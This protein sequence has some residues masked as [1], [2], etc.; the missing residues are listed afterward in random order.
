MIKM[1]LLLAIVDDPATKEILQDQISISGMRVLFA[2]PQVD[3][4]PSLLQN[5]FSLILID[6]SP[7]H[8]PKEVC[9][10][11]KQ[12]S[13]A[14]VLVTMA[15]GGEASIPGCLATCASDCIIKPFRVSELQ[16][17]IQALLARN[18]QQKSSEPILRCSKV[19]L[20]TARR[21]VFREGKEVKVTRTGYKLLVYFMQHQS[22][23]ISKEELLR[24]V[25]GYPGEHAGNN[26]VESAIRR[27]RQDIEED[28]KNPRC[29]HTIWGVGYRFEER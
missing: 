2:D 19:V 4:L 29:L 11:A 26:L 6:L 22:K 1:D 18:E 23:V 12:Y 5:S 8:N 14:P 28:P 10:K 21:K 3:D 16:A 9:L 15:E 27:L 24:E 7:E 25:W 13:T 20:D 17:R